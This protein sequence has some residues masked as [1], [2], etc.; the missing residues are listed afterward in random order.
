MFFDEYPITSIVGGLALAAGVCVAAP[1][2]AG[3]PG[4]PWLCL[5]ALTGSALAVGVGAVTLLFRSPEYSDWPI[6]TP[7]ERPPTTSDTTNLALPEPERAPATFA[8]R[9]D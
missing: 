5:S 6:L 1:A 9:L 4:L 8:A 3:L 2:A 7:E